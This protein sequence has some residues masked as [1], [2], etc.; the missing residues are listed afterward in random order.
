MF[1]LNTKIDIMVKKNIIITNDCSIAKINIKSLT[2]DSE[3]LQFCFF[4]SF[5][6]SNVYIIL[7][8]PAIKNIILIGNIAK[9]SSFSF[10]WKKIVIAL[11]INIDMV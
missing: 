8:N 5:T 7:T 9:D 6:Y 2:I 3:H 1:I 10:F 11:I 4:I